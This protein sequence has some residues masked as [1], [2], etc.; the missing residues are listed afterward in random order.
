[1]IQN[2]DDIICWGC[3]KEINGVLVKKECH[4][5]HVRNP[6]ESPWDHITSFKWRRLLR[7]IKIGLILILVVIAIVIVAVHFLG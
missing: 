5:C 2:Q 1:M 6:E 3:G 4:K 7:Q